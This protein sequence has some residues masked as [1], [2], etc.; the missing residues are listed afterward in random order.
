MKVSDVI[1]GSKLANYHVDIGDN[2]LVVSDD[3]N[4]HIHKTCPMAGIIVF[5]RFGNYVA[6]TC[7]SSR[8][9]ESR[10]LKKMGL[11]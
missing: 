11:V 9:D 1:E 10:M 8:K 3:D 4:G 6:I 7:A 2:S 5:A